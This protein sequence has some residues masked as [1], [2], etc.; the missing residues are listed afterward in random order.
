M[1]KDKAK[2]KKSTTKSAFKLAGFT[3]VM[4]GFGFGLVPLYDV[5]CDV[6]GLNGKTGRIAE[7]QVEAQAKAQA[8]ASATPTAATAGDLDEQRLVTVE[9]VANLNQSMNWAF[10]PQTKVLE[11]ELG[12]VYEVN[13]VA[14]NLDA[15]HVVGRAVPS[16]APTAAARFFN[17]TEC[18]CFVKQELEP[19]EE[20]LMPLRFVV[21]PELPE[22]VKTISLAYT[23]FDVTDEPEPNRT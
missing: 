16:V 7:A 22:H 4:F 6:T 21:S 1:N 18:F 3:V 23:F 14:K 2:V 19:G 5:I 15:L 10:A 17:K 11:V 9:F 20:R 8:G 12:E 13:Y